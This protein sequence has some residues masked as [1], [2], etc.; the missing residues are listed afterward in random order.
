MLTKHKKE[1]APTQEKT[2]K[3]NFEDMWVKFQNTV[4][5]TADQNMMQEER[6]R[7]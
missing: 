3:E 5:V 7:T 2:T 4:L 1:M 6:K